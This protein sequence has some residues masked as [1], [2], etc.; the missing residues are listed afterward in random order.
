MERSKRG[1]P[2]QSP[3]RQATLTS[4]VTRRVDQALQDKIADRLLEKL[5]DKMGNEMGQDIKMALRSKEMEEQI[6]AMY[7]DNKFQITEEE[8]VEE[9]GAKPVNKTFLVSFIL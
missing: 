8:E 9:L 7:D 3:R 5:K 4:N 1:S 2:Y 6:Q